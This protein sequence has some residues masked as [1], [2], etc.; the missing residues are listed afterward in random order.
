M[1]SK[2]V[3][4]RKVKKKRGKKK[5]GEM[6][7]LCLKPQLYY[8]SK[9]TKQRA[10][11]AYEHLQSL[12]E[13][14]LYFAF[15]TPLSLS[16][17]PMPI[18]F[19]NDCTEFFDSFD[20]LYSAIFDCYEKYFLAGKRHLVIDSPETIDL[21]KSI[22]SIPF[23]YSLTSD[24]NIIL[25]TNYGSPLPVIGASYTDPSQNPVYVYIMQNYDFANRYKIGISNNPKFREKT[26][27]SQEPNIETVFKLKCPDRDAAKKI[28]SRLHI[29]FE[30]QRI[31]G[32]W[33]SLTKDELAKAKKLAKIG[34]P[35]TP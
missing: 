16:I 26:L 34:L 32:E 12:N 31:R 17:K 30:Q 7:F 29:F 1:S 25:Y 4:H 14:R 8:H 33:F 13:G 5:R 11:Y 3:N 20:R 2:K 35:E 24:K 23:S 28:E 15:E 19:F 22:L 6:P 21:L 10:I 18:D 27:M 9:M